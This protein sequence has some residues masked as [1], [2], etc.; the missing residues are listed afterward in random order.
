MIADAFS[1]DDA[2]EKRSG[3]E[4]GSKSF[5]ARKMMY[6]F[7]HSIGEK[8]GREDGERESRECEKQTKRRRALRIQF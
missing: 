7:I 4:W 2:D 1:I 3:R 6:K 8:Y 5:A